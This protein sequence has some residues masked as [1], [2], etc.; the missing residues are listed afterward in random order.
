MDLPSEVN[1]AISHKIINENTDV[2][3]FVSRQIIHSFSRLNSFSKE[4]L[5]SR[6]GRVFVESSTDDIF[7]LFVTL[8]EQMAGILL[9]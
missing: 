8:S 4:F 9:F 7:F 2:K 5:N 1:T 6:N 3:L